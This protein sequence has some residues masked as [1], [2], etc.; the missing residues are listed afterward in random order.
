LKNAPNRRLDMSKL[1]RLTNDAR[2]ELWDDPWHEP[3]AEYLLDEINEEVDAALD[4][5]DK[6]HEE[7]RALVLLIGAINERT[8]HPA[9]QHFRQKRTGQH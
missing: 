4:L 9:L 1:P 8:N 5:L 2:D 3:S 6:L 7:A